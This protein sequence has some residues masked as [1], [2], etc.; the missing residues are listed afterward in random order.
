MH[1]A[2]RAHVPMPQLST[3]WPPTLRQLVQQPL[4]NQPGSWQSMGRHRLGHPRHPYHL[5]LLLSCYSHFPQTL[6]S[7]ITVLNCPL[8]PEAVVEPPSLLGHSP[9]L[10]QHLFT[11]AW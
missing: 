8:S 1:R 2:S 10:L 11:P 9:K 3:A 7:S 6:E 5:Q 4:E